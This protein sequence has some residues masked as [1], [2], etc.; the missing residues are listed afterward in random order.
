[1]LYYIVPYIM[2]CTLFT[3]HYYLKKDSSAW[4]LLSV[5]S[6][7]YLEDLVEFFSS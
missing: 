3:Y 2:L 7:E 6:L 4:S 5:L 1:M